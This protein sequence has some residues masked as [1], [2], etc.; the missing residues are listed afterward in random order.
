MIT[1]ET[2]IF[3]TSTVSVSHHVVRVSDGAV[4]GVIVSQWETETPDMFTLDGFPSGSY[5]R[6]AERFGNVPQG[7]FDDFCGVYGQA[8]ADCRGKYR[9]VPRHAG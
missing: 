3:H 6:G 8:A 9:F 7:A 2:Y 5:F 1:G 4:V